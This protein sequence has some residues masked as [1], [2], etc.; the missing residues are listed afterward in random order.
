MSNRGQ[1][2]DLVDD[3]PPSE[4]AEQLPMPPRG[5]R[6]AA[7]PA[8]TSSVPSAPGEPVEAAAPTEPPAPAEPEPTA[9][10]PP[11]WLRQVREATDPQ[12][13]VATLL[14][15]VPIEELEKHPSIAGWIGDMGN[16]RARALLAQQE[17]DRLE[18]QKRE[19][20]AQGDYYGLGQLAAT[21]IQQR[22]QQQVTAQQAAP[23][24]DGVVAF[25]SKLPPEVQAQISGK[26]FGAGKSYAEGVSEYLDAITQATI[27]H[28]LNEAVEREIKRREPALR[29]AMLS[30]TNGSGPTPELDGGPAPSSREIT[31]EQIAAMS[32]E[33][34]DALFDANG[35]PKPGTRVRLT[36][37]VDTRRQR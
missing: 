29:K 36:R 1:H 10:E 17:Q 31:D 18:Q 24:M 32:L 16:K 37:G 22:A 15:N 35:R 28:R 21:E 2:P 27:S 19:A 11:E 7:R 20:A 8:Q 6:S 33:E 14:K 34:Y 9:S 30:E 25:Q 4:P 3:E 23:F 26:S 13:M 5:R 12:T